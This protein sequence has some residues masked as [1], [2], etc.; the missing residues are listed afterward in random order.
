MRTDLLLKELQELG[1]QLQMVGSQLKLSA[2]EGTLTPELLERVKENK[3]AIITYISQLGTAEYRPI[4]KAPKTNVYPLSHSQRRLWVLDQL[5]GHSATYNM[6]ARFRL[7]GK[8][9]RLALSTSFAKLVARHESLRTVFVLEEG[10]P[11]QSILPSIGPF[12]NEVD[13]STLASPESSADAYI[14]DFINAGFD[15]GTGPLLRVALLR[16]SSEEHMLIW[17]IHHIVSDEWSVQVMVR[18]LV[19]MYNSYASGGQ[20]S[21]EALGIQY[22]DYAVWQQKE[23]SGGQLALHRDYWLSCF[24]GELPLLDLPADHSRPQVQAHRGDQLSFEFD[25]VSGRSYHSILREQ[26]A[27]LFMGVL[28]LVKVLLYR[29]SG[30][31]DITVST[32]IAGRHHPDL[33]GQVGYYLNTLALRNNVDGTGSFKKLLSS[34]RE[35][36]LSGFE[37]QDYPFD[38]LVEDLG[39]GGDLSRSPLSD[40]VVI[41]QNINLNKEGELQLQGL[42]VYAEPVPLEI[43]KGDLRFQFFHDEQRDV[44]HGNIEYNSDIFN[45]ERIERMAVHLCRL[46]DAVQTDPDIM[47]NCLDY[48][49]EGEM[50]DV[51]WFTAK[52]PIKDHPLLHRLIEERALE[53]P[54]RLALTGYGLELSYGKLNSYANRLAH[55]LI[56]LGYSNGRAVG[57]YAEGGPLQVVALLACFKAG[58]VYVPM[59]SE[60]AKRHLDQ[61]MEETDMQAVVTIAEHA[62]SLREFLS[63]RSTPI[64][65]VFVLDSLSDGILSLTFEG[66]DELDTS[67]LDTSNKYTEYDVAGSA[68]VFYTSGSTGR[69]KGI[70]GSHASLSHYIQWH[71]REW[72]VDSSFRVSQ[73]APMTFDASLKDILTTLISGATLYLPSSEIKNNPVR[74][75][76]WLKENNITLLQ[77]VPSV[78]R[79]IT[80]AVLE[81]KQVLPALH[82]VVLAGERLYGRDVLNWKAA[83]GTAARLSNM[84]GLT[85]TTI[86]KTCFHVDKW[87]WNP[88]DVLP[89]GFPITNTLT[90]IVNHSNNICETGEIGEVYIKSPYI[91]NGYI[92]PQLNDQHL[93]PN[94]LSRDV[95]DPVWRTGDLGRYRRDG[96]IEIVGR[97]DEQVKINGVRVE[98]EHIRSVLLEQDDIIRTELVVHTSADFRQELMCYYMGREYVPEELRALLSLKLNTTMLPSYYIWMESFPMNMNGKVDR[99]ALPKPQEVLS[100]AV[101]HAPQSELESNLA[102]LWQQVLDLDRVGREDNF[103]NIGGSSMKAIQLIARIY[104]ELDVQLTIADLFFHPVLWQMS[105][106]VSS[107][108]GGSYRPIPKAPKTNVYPLS[109]S[110]RRLWVLDQLQ[111]HSATYNMPARFRL[112]GKLDRLALS[113]SF[114]KLVARHESLR[115]VF[116]LEEGIPCQSILPSIGPFWNEVDFSTLASPESSA[117]AYIRDFINAGFDLGTGP[118][119]RVA[120]LRLSSEEHMLIWSIHH[121]VSDEWS[122]QV[123]VRE[124]VSMYNS[125]ASG[126]QPSLEALGIQ[127]KDY[128]VWQQKEFSGGQLALHRDYWLSCFTGELPLLDLPADHSRP[129]V[130]AHRGDQLSFEF[131]AVS[132]RS[133]HSILRE[134]DATLFMGVLALVKVLLYRYSGQS[135]ITVSTPIAGRHHP[136]LEGQVGYYLNTLA[137]R[138]NVDGTGSFKKLLSS[139]RET[140][141]SGFEHQDY[142]FDMLVEDLGLGGDLSRSPLSDVVVILQNINLNKEG[143]LQLQGLE[144]Y[145]EPVPLEISKGDLRF[146]FFHDEQRDVLH[147]NIEYNSDIFN[148]ERIERMAVH[149]CRL[150]DAVQ[151]DPDIMINDLEYL[152]N[153]EK[154]HSIKSTHSFNTHIDKGR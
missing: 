146:Q 64:E 105:E 114:A 60:Q 39:L 87:D 81:T 18:E 13:F 3:E 138:N 129:Q 104:R 142:P 52:L 127:Y 115:T 120:L 96:S 62:D 69:S 149:L 118:L 29:Y 17:S 124:L 110:Q 7:L 97:C 80:A 1:V 112:L 20:P 32:P 125:Y 31:S 102:V 30:Q 12:W 79:L 63:G 22:K 28:A 95:E 89:V 137:L 5:Q 113:T 35:T 21:L 121:I 71:Q 40:V 109:H 51:S 24:T 134:Q 26:D 151:T 9:D 16:L 61:V 41:L 99:K 94:P 98:L 92:H 148:R 111:G 131:D 126:G 139:V 147:G 108:K 133:Y 76:E 83:N 72:G 68:Y 50:E 103:F 27:T 116:V 100:G 65:A 49:L 88:G 6:P 33:E 93:L 132:G 117:D 56:S 107:S 54:L 66:H 8:L 75:T 4:P 23:F 67:I 84:Y 145:A 136:D 101:Y 42:E 152:D 150:M 119:L 45:R 15:L 36:T 10:I 43:S 123:M 47:I 143:E 44:L 57:V 141:L 38:M 14:R 85:E 135:D 59:S 82:Y 46:M 70:I 11:C 128:A 153:S 34:V 91:S 106:L 55:G 73:L 90:A 74:L 53:H 86:L 37:H 144:V 154:H 130:Q 140:T 78:F 122:V 48:R 19:S 25:A 77:T 58:A 2:T